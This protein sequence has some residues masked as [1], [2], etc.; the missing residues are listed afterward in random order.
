M[1]LEPLKRRQALTVAE[2]R[3]RERRFLR[4]PYFI[5]EDMQSAFYD[6]VVNNRNSKHR[7]YAITET[8]NVMPGEPITE[9]IGMGGITNIEWENGNAEISLILDPLKRGKG[10]GAE[11]VDLLLDEAF[12]NIGLEMIYGEVYNCGNKG[13]WERIVEKYNEYSTILPERKMYQGIRYDSLWFC[14]REKKWRRNK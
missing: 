4:T 7:Y 12:N 2:W 11:A 14:I 13:F 8:V 6:D 10:H 9:L 1:N 5:T 3:N